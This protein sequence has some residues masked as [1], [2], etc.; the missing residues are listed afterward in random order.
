VA[1]E[2][3]AVARASFDRCVGAPDFFPAFYRNLFRRLPT[4]E[5]RF[6]MTDME[7]QHKLLRHALGLLLAYAAQ[8]T[9]EGNLLSRV[10]VRHGREDLQIPAADYPH[11]VEALIETIHQHDPGCDPPTEAAW[12][13]ALE[14]GIRYMQSRA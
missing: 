7:R 12:R 14:P 9:G 5:P 6:A 2:A 3:V 1:E 11:F 4:A 10:A 8:R 13:R